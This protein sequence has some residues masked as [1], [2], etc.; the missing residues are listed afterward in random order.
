MTDTELQLWIEHSKKSGWLAALLN[1]IIPGVGYMYCGRWVLGF[2]VLV[3]LVPFEVAA[4]VLSLLGISWLLLSIDLIL[5]ADGF[6]AARRYNRQLVEDALASRRRVPGLRPQSGVPAESTAEP[7]AWAPPR[8]SRPAEAT[9]G[10]LARVL[11]G[12][13]GLAAIGMVAYGLMRFHVLARLTGGSG[14]ATMVNSPESTAATHGV[15]PS[16]DCRKATRRVERLICSTPGLARADHTLANL[17]WT[18]LK[19][20]GPEAAA[21]KDGQRAFLRRRD[22]CATVGCI[23]EAYKLRWEQITQG[24]NGMSSET[25]DQ[26]AQPADSARSDAA[27][28]ANCSIFARVSVPAIEDPQSILQAGQS[29]DFITQYVVDDKGGVASFCEH[30]G[31]CYPRYLRQGGR[32][33]EALELRNCRIDPKGTDEDGQTFHE[34]IIDRSQFSKQDLRYSDVRDTLSEMGLCSA[35]ADNAAD[36]YV[37]K[38]GS[39][40]AHLVKGALEGN[41]NARSELL[42]DPDFCR[43]TDNGAG[44]GP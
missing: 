1:L 12:V 14:V 33:V 4:F 30:G 5:V 7:A 15:K 22:H 3:F 20:A 43:V 35:C 32:R 9:E 21:L 38:P 36:F 10:R 11:V 37:N 23:A 19:A 44:Q 18:T 17:Y 27:G 2:L 31:F 25:T 16:F 41:P 28:E 34:L 29:E 6:L 13:A 26:G 40:C 39:E 42:Q 24:R 8:I